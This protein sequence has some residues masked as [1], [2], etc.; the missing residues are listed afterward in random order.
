MWLLYVCLLA[1][2]STCKK[3]IESPAP[4]KLPDATQTGANTFGCML[5]GNI[6]VAYGN[7]GG[8]NPG[9]RPNPNINYDATYNGGSLDLG[10]SI[11]YDNKPQSSI[12]ITGN[13]ISA[14]GEYT[15]KNSNILFIYQDYTIPR[16]WYS[17]ECIST[18]KLTIIKL[19][20]QNKIISGTFEF[21][22]ERKNDGY[23]VVANDGR[24]DIKYL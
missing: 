18:Y 6:W 10:G 17:D 5:N 16:T 2:L 4:T 3:C 21:S 15:T 7:F 22:M 12:S 19:D 14:L 13:N 9:Q 8:F 24:F 11:F 1:C 23:K 20:L